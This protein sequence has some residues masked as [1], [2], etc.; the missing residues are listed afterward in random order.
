MKKTNVDKEVVTPTLEP[1]AEGKKSL[2]IAIA[3]P[4]SAGDAVELAQF[5]GEMVALFCRDRDEKKTR[6]GQR[7]M[8]SVYIAQLESTEPLAGIMFQSYF[9]D[10]EIGQWYIG[11]VT[12]VKTGNNL[13]WILTMDGLKK[14]E[15]A[16]LAAHLENVRLDDD[17][18]RSL[19]D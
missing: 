2:N 10:L 14:D 15:V 7:K 6:F 4:K 12:R 1:V 8:T 11:I 17:A 13:Q 19:L 9:Q 16:K 5:D 3:P 18:R